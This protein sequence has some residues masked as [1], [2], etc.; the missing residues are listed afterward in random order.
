[1]FFSIEREQLAFAFDQRLQ[2]HRTGPDRVEIL[3]R[4][5]CI[6][7]AQVDPFMPVVEQQ[8]AAILEVA[9]HDLTGE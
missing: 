3:Q 8:L 1:M 2:V 4:V 9:V 5:L 7:D 6:V